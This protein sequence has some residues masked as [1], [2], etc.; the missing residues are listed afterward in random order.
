MD[1]LDISDAVSAFGSQGRSFCHFW[2]GVVCQLLHDLRYLSAETELWA[3]QI[4]IASARIFI[5]FG[6]HSST[7]GFHGA[8]VLPSRLADF[9]LTA[10]EPFGFYHGI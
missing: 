3:A 5:Q 9:S 8:S 4:L 6:A 7:D 10:L 2:N 1:T